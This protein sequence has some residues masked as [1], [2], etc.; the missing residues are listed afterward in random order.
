[1]YVFYERLLSH[2]L[3]HKESVALSLRN[4]MRTRREALRDGDMKK[5]DS[6][7]WAAFVVDSAV[8]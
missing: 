7:Q 6:A 5:D 1:M 4:A 2:N 3:S 8:P